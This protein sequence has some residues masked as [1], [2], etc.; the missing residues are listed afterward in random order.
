MTRIIQAHVEITA[1]VDYEHPS[2][3]KLGPEELEDIRVR[4]DEAIRMTLNQ[5]QGKWKSVD[6]LISTSA[7]DES[8]GT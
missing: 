2:Y 7:A 4:V 6:M 3:G 8:Y 5:D 1:C